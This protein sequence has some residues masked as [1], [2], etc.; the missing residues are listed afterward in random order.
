M[1]RSR[2]SRALVAAALAILTPAL[3]GCYVYVPVEEPAP[4][5]TIRIHVPV[6]SAADNPNRAQETVSFEGT[7]LASGDTLLL[8]TK[9]RR[10]FGAFR[11]IIELDTLRIAPSQL[12]GMEQRLRSKPK[13]YAFSGVLALG[14]AALVAG[15]IEVAGGQAGDEGPG[16]NGTTTGAVV[17]NVLSVLKMLGGR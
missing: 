3:S 15:A 1:S 2:P 9:V 17:M 4:G 5:S 6:P 14:V 10:Q 11:E 12:A 16:E 13:T 8:E 7:V